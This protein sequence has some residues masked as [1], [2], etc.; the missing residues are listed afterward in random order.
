MNAGARAFDTG[1]GERSGR[2]ELAAMDCG[3]RGPRRCSSSVGLWRRDQGGR[4]TI[5]ERSDMVSGVKR[6]EASG[7]ISVIGDNRDSLHGACM[8]PLTNVLPGT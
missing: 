4:R 2:R 6:R 3:T 8:A 7:G 1:F 5:L